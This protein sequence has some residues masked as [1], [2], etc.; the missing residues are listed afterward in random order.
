MDKMK[1]TKGRELRG[2]LGEE[3]RETLLV[4]FWKECSPEFVRSHLLTPFN[5]SWSNTG[6]TL[7]ASV[8]STGVPGYGCS[9]WER[10]VLTQ[11]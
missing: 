5:S 1:D 3:E 7:L 6:P 10:N 11:K 2:H 8:G 9:T 4:P